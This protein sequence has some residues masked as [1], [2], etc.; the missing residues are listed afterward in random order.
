[1]IRILLAEDQTMF[2]RAVAE[3]LSREP[4]LEIVG[5]VERGDSV[6][7][8][9]VQ[10]R[11][12][13][14]LIDIEMPYMD[15]M[16]VAGQLRRELPGCRTLILTVFGRPGYVRRAIDLGV[17]GF[18][19]KE[20]T[21]YDLVAAIRWVAMGDFVFDPELLLSTLKHGTSPLTPR[22]REVLSLSWRGASAEEV[23]QHLHLSA[24]TVR[25]YL[26]KVIQK[27]GARNKIEAARIA[28]E[29][30]WL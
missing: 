27:L 15:G 11:P 28:E 25:N 2:R 6:V 24:A 17:G 5:E 21:P 18:I 29:T 4:D 16:T 9:A 14:V 20:S 12:N 10:T 26:S 19:L 30:G 1:M 22:E 13:V 8:L 23:A 3:V 7:E